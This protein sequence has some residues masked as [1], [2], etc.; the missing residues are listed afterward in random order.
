MGE[1]RAS[2]IGGIRDKSRQTGGDLER[3]IFAGKCY[4]K[5]LKKMGVGN[6]EEHPIKVTLPYLSEK[7]SI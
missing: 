5:S 6:E 4:S 7:G 1:K 2:L 3:I